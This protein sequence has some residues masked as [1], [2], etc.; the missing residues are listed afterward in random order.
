MFV[1]SIDNI[2]AREPGSKRVHVIIDT[3]AGSRNKYKYDSELMMFRISRILPEGSV[4]PYDFG[5]IPGTRAED[6]DPLDVMLLGLAPTFPGCVVT[7]RLLGV[8]RAQQVE[9]RRQVRND[10]LIAVA[11]TPVNRSTMK[12]LN[13]ISSEQLR[14]IEHFFVSYNLFQGRNFR[15]SGRGGARMAEALVTEG[16]RQSSKA[17]SR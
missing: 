13:S 10:R 1:S 2:P 14:A 17:H 15:I 7:A 4:F 3:P 8:L 16:M 6:G 5:F 12:G 9:K 11:E